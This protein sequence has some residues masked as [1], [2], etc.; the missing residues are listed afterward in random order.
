MC[1]DL[2]LYINISKAAADADCD[3]STEGRI[4]IRSQEVGGTKLPKAWVCYAKKWV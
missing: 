1:F 2:Q 4:S 3:D